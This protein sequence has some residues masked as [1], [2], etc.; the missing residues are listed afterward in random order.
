[1]YDLFIIGGGING[2]GIAHDA[3]GRGLKV[4]LCEQDDFASGTSWSSTKLIHGGLRYLEHYEFSLVRKALLERKRLLQNAPHLI[5]PLQFILPHHPELRPA[6]LIRLGL[7]F[8]DHLTL[9]PH[10][11]RS[12]G[13][14]LKKHISGKPLKT[15]FKKGFCYTDCMTDDARLVIANAQAADALGAH[16]MPQT[17]FKQAKRLAN[18]WEIECRNNI[19]GQLIPLRAKIIINASGP[20]VNGLLPDLLN[21]TREPLHLVKGSHIVV[22]ALFNHP[23]AYILQNKDGR[24][25]FMIP[26]EKKFT[27]IGTTEVQVDDVETAPEMNL[28]ECQYLCEQVSNYLKKSIT[29]N[30]VIWHYSGV[31]PLLAGEATH[32]HTKTISRDYQLDIDREQAP[33][34]TILG[35][36]LTTY[37]LLAEECVDLLKQDFPDLP[38]AWTAHTKLPGSD[39]PKGGILAQAKL[40]QTQAPWLPKSLAERWANTYGRLSEKLIAPCDNIKDLGKHYGA[41]LYQREIDYLRAHEWAHHADDILWRRTKLGL[42]MNDEAQ[43]AL[44]QALNH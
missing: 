25:I 17:E 6:W 37:R 28:D 26:Y 18:H 24:V 22:P 31:R 39:L 30:D 32:A 4:A 20:W 8:Y 15:N 29:P 35:G 42:S 23:F 43:L 5:K 13:V 14:N 44:K 7:F 11:P 9:R 33:C 27:L 2:V 12:F 19:T 16:L 21:H 40:L 1:M 41:G 10:L 36:K 3:C 38:P 34:I